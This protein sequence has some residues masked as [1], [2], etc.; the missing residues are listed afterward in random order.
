MIKRSIV[1]AG[2]QGTGKTTLS[3]AI[4]K[5][6]GLEYRAVPTRQFMPEGISSHMDV[7]RMAVLS[8]QQG[9]DF[10]S[11]LIEKRARL[12][13]ELRGAAYVSDRSVFD[14]YAYYVMHN[15]MFANEEHTKM[16]WE[17]TAN[18]INDVDLTVLLTPNLNQIVSDGVRITSS[19]YYE[20]YTSVLMDFIIRAYIN[21]GNQV[22]VNIEPRESSKSGIRGQLLCPEDTTKF[23]SLLH[24]I[25]PH[26]FGTVEDRLMIIDAAIQ[27]L[28][29]RVSDVP[30]ESSYFINP[31][32][33][34]H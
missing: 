21:N 2:A 10:Q 11:T 22:S 7:L 20:A 1:L 26:G 23:N 17:K 25:E 16:L 12:F 18:S 6:F 14:S 3:D 15:S 34:I 28:E 9:I 27:L 5:E 29:M 19:S 8:P 32:N 31:S 24:I 30:V 13:S 4:Q 33:K